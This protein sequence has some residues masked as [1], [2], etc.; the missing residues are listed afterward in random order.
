[1]N[2]ESKR[3]AR[4]PINLLFDLFD[5]FLKALI[6]VFIIQAV[7]F[8]ICTVVGNSMYPALQ[9]GEKLIIS[10]FLYE[11][12][13]ND[14][15]VFHQTGNLNEPVVKRVIATGGKWVKIDFENAKI[16]VSIDDIFDESDVIE[17]SHAY[18]DAGY[19]TRT[20]SEPLVC[21]VEEGYLFVMGDNRNHSLDST[22]DRMGTI[23]RESVLGKVIFRIFPF[24]RVGIV[25]R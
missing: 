16:Y 7:F 5:C 14:I 1:M 21:Y 13:E 23:P 2:P 4:S 17:D 6:A 24:E 3:S 18:L 20:Y 19:Y 22:S 10:N 25:K 8:Q 11:P 12:R 9:N 15:I